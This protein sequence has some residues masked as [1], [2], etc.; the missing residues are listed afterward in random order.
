MNL[1]ERKGFTGVP[2]K[3]FL[4]EIKGKEVLLVFLRKSKIPLWLFSGK[5]LY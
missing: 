1:E 2:I 4:C 3:S 5:M